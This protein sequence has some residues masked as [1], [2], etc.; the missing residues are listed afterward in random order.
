MPDVPPDELQHKY[1]ALQRKL[2]PLWQVIGRPDLGG[3][4]EDENTIIVIPSLTVDMALTTSIQQAYEERFLFMLLLLRQPRVRLVYVTSGEVAPTIVDYY[5]HLLPGVTSSNARKRLF[6]VSPL[7][8]SSR[9]LSRKLLDRPRLL[10]HIRSLAIDVDRAH[11]VP[12][13][14]TDLER[15]LAVRLGIPMYA[16]DPRFFALG[17]K[18]GSRRIF[19]EEGVSHPGGFED[20]TSEEDVVAALLQMR[21]ARPAMQRAIVKLNEGVSGL[22]NAVVE[23]HGV[24]IPGDPG[25]YAAVQ[26][27]LREMQLE[28]PEATYAAYLQKLQESGAIVEEFLGGDEIRSPSAQIRVT[29]LGDVELLSTHDQVLG[30]PSGQSYLGARFP[31]DQAYG[32]AIMREAAKVAHRFARE[33]VIGRFALDFVVVRTRDGEWEPF[34]IEVNLRKGGT[35]HPFLTLQYLTDGHFDAALGEFVTSRGDRKCYWASDHVES[36]A[37][38]MFTPDA[39]F[40]IVS[41]HHLHFDHALQTGV[42]LH[43]VSGVGDLGR[44]GMTVIADTHEAVEAMYGRAIAIFDDEA[45]AAS[46][47]ESG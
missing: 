47:A 31:A 25:E 10:E 14:T 29:P 45:D 8:G 32:P 4:D 34:A 5:L 18:S 28:S 9:P 21:R 1:D 3:S 19:A 23:L 46:R 37:Y 16:A 38:C 22:G 30:G 2:V 39:L 11:I 15:E 6:L 35:T 43:M 12:F 36:P 41:R 33:G 24:P 26:G 20:L 17:T 13:N 7:D 44:F 42:I 40:D 27:R